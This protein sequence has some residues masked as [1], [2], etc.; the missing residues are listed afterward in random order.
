MIVNEW[1]AGVMTFANQAEISTLGAFMAVFECIANFVDP[2]C[3][4]SVLRL[5][6]APGGWVGRD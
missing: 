5:D 1:I 4:V 2:P 3:L 6:P